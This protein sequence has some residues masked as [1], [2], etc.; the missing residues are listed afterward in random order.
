[1]ILGYKLNLS[2]LKGSKVQNV[3]KISVVTGDFNAGPLA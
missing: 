1:M 2:H 3:N